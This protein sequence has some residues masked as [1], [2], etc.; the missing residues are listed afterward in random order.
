MAVPLLRTAGRLQFCHAEG[1]GHYQWHEDSISGA[2]NGHKG[3]PNDIIPPVPLLLPN[4]KNWN[5]SASEAF[6]NGQCGG[7]SPEPPNADANANANCD[8]LSVDA[9]GYPVGS[10]VEVVIDGSTTL[11]PV[12]SQ[13]NLHKVYTWTQTVDHTWSVTVL[14]PNMDLMGRRQRH[15][16]RLPA[17]R[18][19]CDAGESDGGAGRV[20]GWCDDA[21][22][23]DVAAEWW[24][25]HVLDQPHLVAGNQVTVT[26]TLS[27]GYAWVSPL[28]TPWLPGDPAATKATYSVRLEYVLCTP[29]VPLDPTVTQATCANACGDGA[30]GDA[31]DRSGRGVLHSWLRRVRTR[32]APRTTR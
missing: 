19:G 27:A 11:D 13:G 7:T 28:P 3:H 25:D 12:D 31:G 9:T 2:V 20:C 32:Q 21:G 23:G 17:A 18:D 8:G 24:G 15:E 16:D 10:K 4:G 5:G 1:N 22:V 30:D 14:N 29:V 26:A 6:L